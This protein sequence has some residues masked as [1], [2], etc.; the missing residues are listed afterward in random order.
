LIYSK[1][2]IL[3]VTAGALKLLKWCKKGGGEKKGGLFYFKAWGSLK[4][5]IR[6]ELMIST[7]NL[8]ST[9]LK[10]NYFQYKPTYKY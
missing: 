7:K 2:E 10:K 8:L 4:G 3:A 6:T 9:F 1:I 5:S